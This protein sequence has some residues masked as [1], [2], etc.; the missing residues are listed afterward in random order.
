MDEVESGIEDPENE[1]ASLLENIRRL[2]SRGIVSRSEVLDAYHRGKRDAD[3]SGESVE[4]PAVESRGRFARS[5]YYLGGLIVFVGIALLLFQNWTE[6]SRFAKILLTLGFGSVTL[7]VAVALDVLSMAERFTRAFYYLSGLVLPLGLFVTY[8]LFEFDIYAPGVVTQ[9]TGLLFL[10]YLILLQFFDRTVLLSFVIVFGSW[11][12]F[13]LTDWVFVFGQESPGVRFYYY[14]TLFVSVGWMVLARYTGRSSRPVLSRTL[15]GFGNVAFLAAGFALGGW[16]PGRH[17]AWELAFPFM[18]LFILWVSV[19]TGSR[20][21]LVVSSL[22]LIAYL[23]RLTTKYFQDSFGWPLALVL[24]G[25]GVM[26]I[27]SVTYVLYDR[28][29]SF[30]ES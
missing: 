1:K 16:E 12:Y 25:F 7:A 20:I 30:A 29:F 5:L 3:Q 18:V 17:F 23:T 9:V 21:S 14:R 28:L 22:F 26:S 10:A 11:C 13:G 24:L 27:G 4:P 15:W 2:A 8:H 19:S 6:L